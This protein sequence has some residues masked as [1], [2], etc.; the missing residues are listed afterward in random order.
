MTDQAQ[1]HAYLRNDG[2]SRGRGGFGAFEFAARIGGSAMRGLSIQE[3]LP[4]LARLRAGD[5]KFCARLLCERRN[6][7]RTAV[8]STRATSVN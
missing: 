5:D 2:A 8:R 1:E 6:L 7:V 3:S 4:G